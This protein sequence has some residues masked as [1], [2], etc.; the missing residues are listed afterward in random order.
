MALAVQHAIG[1]LRIGA[2]QDVPLER[3]ALGPVCRAL[4]DHSLRARRFAESAQFLVPRARIFGVVSLVKNLS[5]MGGE[6][7]AFPK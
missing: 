6:V 3:V 5:R 1:H 2:I 7:A 4:P